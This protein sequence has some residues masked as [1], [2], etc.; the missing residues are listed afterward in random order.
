MSPVRIQRQRTRGWRKPPEAVVVTRPS[1]WG[2]P[3]PVMSGDGELF[4]RADAVRMYRELVLDGITC[5]RSG[6]H[7][8]TFRRSDRPGHPLHVP[9]VDVIRRELAGRDLVC[10]C[11]LDVDCHADFLLDIANTADTHQDGDTTP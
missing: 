7:E 6:D 1:P 9:T 10:W 5:F 11:A 8:H 4:P 3:F 2:N